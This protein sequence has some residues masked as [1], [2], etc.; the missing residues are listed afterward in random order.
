MDTLAN[1]A[2]SLDLR[3]EVLRV[4]RSKLHAK[5]W[6]EYESRFPGIVPSWYK[7]L[8]QDFAFIDVHLGLPRWD[9]EPWGAHFCFRSPQD[10]IFDTE[11]DEE[12]IPHGWFPFAEEN[13]GNLWAMRANAPQDSPIILISHTDGGVEAEHGV[14]Y[15]AHNL[16]HLLATAS[17]RGGKEH[18]TADGFV[19][20]SKA[21]YKM[22][23][24]PDTHLESL[25]V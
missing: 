9:D 11:D 2:K 20:A 24:E 16:S 10:E 3:L 4:S 25:G 1:A 5:A 15:A 18:L 6:K 13:D 23:G 7:Q 22:W 17:I 8:L 19:D 12:I 21:G 14:K